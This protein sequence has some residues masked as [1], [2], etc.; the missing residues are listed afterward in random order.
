MIKILIKM[1]FTINILNIV[2]TKIEIKNILM[3][4]NKL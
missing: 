1:L 3:Y 2:K 4:E